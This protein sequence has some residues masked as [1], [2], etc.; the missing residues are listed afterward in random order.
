MFSKLTIIIFCCI[1]FL[2]L[3]SISGCFEPPPPPKPLTRAETIPVDAVKMTPGTD[4]YRPVLNPAYSALWEAPVPLTGL[5]NTAG[6]EDAPVIS[7]D[8]NI[9]YFFFTPDV[10]V[11]PEKQLLDKITGIWQSKK[12]NGVWSEPTRVL[13]NN[14]IALDGPFCIQGNILWFGSYR[15]GNY[16]DDPDI[17]TASQTNGKWTWQNAGTRL[18]VDFK[19]G[20]LYTSPDGNTMI[21]QQQDTSPLTSSGFGEYDLWETT[22]TDGTWTA[23]VNLGPLI[24]TAG[25]EGWLFLSSDGTELWFTRMSSSLGYPGPAIFRSIKGPGGWGAPEE[26]VSRF[27]GDPG[28]DGAGNLYFT[29]HYYS[30]DLQTM[31][32]ADI[33]VAYHK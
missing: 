15:A 9:F 18:N 12:I 3:I 8:G 31:I 29:H 28:L 22:K 13:L 19:T 33:Y 30:Q 16:G 32:E 6:A 23:P 21:F 24:N 20:E 26:I 7:Q 4:F 25:K 11:P 1:L 2:G 10:R 14:D 27:A 17:Y 5:V